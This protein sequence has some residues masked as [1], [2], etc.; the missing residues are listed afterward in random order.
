[1]QKQQETT[2][3]SSYWLLIVNDI[4]MWLSHFYI[5]YHCMTA[6][7]HACSYYVIVV[8]QCLLFHH[9]E[10]NYYLAVVRTIVHWCAIQKVIIWTAQRPF[11]YTATINNRHVD[12]HTEFESVLVV[13][14]NY[15]ACWHALI[16]AACRLW[17]CMHACMHY[18]S[19]EH[20]MLGTLNQTVTI[21]L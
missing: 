6:C 3:K 18:L 12:C 13:A 8:S 5:L 1:M 15:A 16:D 19:N 7:M 2:A 9:A 21:I 10:S 17:V 20:F 11:I 4:K 14:K